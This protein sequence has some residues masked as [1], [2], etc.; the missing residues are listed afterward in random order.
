MVSRGQW[1]EYNGFV[2]KGPHA[3]DKTS[4][5]WTES[6][7]ALTEEVTLNLV[8]ERGDTIHFEEGGAAATKS[9]AKIDKRIHKTTAMEIS[10]L[11]VDSKG[12]HETGAPTT[13]TNQ[14]VIKHRIIENG[15]ERKFELQAYPAG[16]EITYTTDNTDPTEAGSLYAAPFELP[17]TCVVV[18]AIAVLGTH[19]TAKPFIFPIPKKGRKFEIDP[20]IPATWTHTLS[21]ATTAEVYTLLDHLQACNA[22]ISDIQITAM[23][24]GADCAELMV[25]GPTRRTIAEAKNTVKFLQDLIPQ[26]EA[27]IDIKA[28]YFELG[29]ELKKLLE[30]LELP[31]KPEEIK[32]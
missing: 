5:R 19:R 29:S 3:K 16:A 14:I 26:A 4:I 32:Q 13:W 20:N 25:T 7:D 24:G 8:P 31:A 11:V 22:K 12:E 18:Q 1:K 30:L 15:S 17:E 9:S 28:S 6:R 2:H 10:F 23:K 27:S 21:A